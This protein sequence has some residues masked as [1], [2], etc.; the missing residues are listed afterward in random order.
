MAAFFVVSSQTAKTE[1]SA[2]LSPLALSLCLGRHVHPNPKQKRPAPEAADPKR[3]TPAKVAIC[4][5]NVLSEVVAR[6]TYL[7]GAPRSCRSRDGR[8]GGYPLPSPIK[9][10]FRRSAPRE[11]GEA[12]PRRGWEGHPAA[13]GPPHERGAITRAFWSLRGG[14]IPQR[15]RG[16]GCTPHRPT[17]GG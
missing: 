13:T 6:P 11:G 14:M 4:A 1:I 8:G 5:R 9:G 3:Q 15:G 7:K 16:V 17:C 10:P 2:H 12:R